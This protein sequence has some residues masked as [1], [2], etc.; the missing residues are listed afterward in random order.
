M[1]NWDDKDWQ[2]DWKQLDWEK[3][4]AKE[5]ASAN[6]IEQNKKDLKSKESEQIWYA[7]RIRQSDPIV[8]AKHAWYARDEQ[9]LHPKP[10]E[11]TIGKFTYAEF[12]STSDNPT[13]QPLRIADG[14]AEFDYVGSFTGGAHYKGTRDMSEIL[15]TQ[16]DVIV[17]VDLDL[18]YKDLN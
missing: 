11:I 14:Y 7:F 5:W 6:W 12:D 18:I 13:P 15:Q 3:A 4:N 16:T 17:N 9:W 10:T 2:P 8:R 1:S